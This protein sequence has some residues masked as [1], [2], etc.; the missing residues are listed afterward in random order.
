MRYRQ[1]SDP[2]HLLR[3]RLRELPVNRLSYG[4][5]RLHALLQGE[6]WKINR[7]RVYRL[8]MLE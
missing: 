3:S 2:Q 1:R 6:G 7:K 5:L 8:Y 4:S